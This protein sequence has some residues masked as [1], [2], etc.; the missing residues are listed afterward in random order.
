MQFGR[1]L[2]SYERLKYNNQIRIHKDD[3]Y[4]NAHQL[5][6]KNDI[7]EELK[8]FL[9]N[10][11]QNKE[12]DI[13]LLKAYDQG[14]LIDLLNDSHIDIGQWKEDTAKEKERIL[15]VLIGE[16]KAGNTNKSQLMQFLNY[17][18]KQNKITE[19]KYNEILNKYV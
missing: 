7:T 5:H 11:L 13:K 4:C 18:L 6:D 12:V 2:I 16:M 9:L 8:A 14:Y 1:F 10:L 17:Q 15:N 19:N 3:G